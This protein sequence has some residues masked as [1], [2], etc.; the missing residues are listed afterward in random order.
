MANSIT[1]L[2]ARLL[3]LCAAVMPQQRSTIWRACCKPEGPKF[4]ARRMVVFASED[5]GLAAPAALNVA[6]STFWR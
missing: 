1:T 6:V 3:N 5:I 2:L 4:I